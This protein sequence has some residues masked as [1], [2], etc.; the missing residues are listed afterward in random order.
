MRPDHAVNPG[1]IPPKSPSDGG[2]A[3]VSHNPSPSQTGRSPIPSP[4]HRM[5]D[6]FLGDKKIASCGVAARAGNGGL[7]YFCPSCGEIWGRVLLGLPRWDPVSIPCEAHGKSQ[8]GTAFQGGS[9]LYPLIWWDAP[10]GF[11]L[12]DQLKFL[13]PELIRYE[14]EIRARRILREREAP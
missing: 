1:A 13:S 7:A 4:P 3:P 8:W 12:A 10:N 11:S 9:F 5:R 6:F 14:A 2:V